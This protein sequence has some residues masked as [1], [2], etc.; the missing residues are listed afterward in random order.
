MEE[1]EFTDITITIART[2]TGQGGIVPELPCYADRWSFRMEPH[3]STI[4]PPVLV[5]WYGR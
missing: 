3:I 1:T 2:E 4:E 5:V